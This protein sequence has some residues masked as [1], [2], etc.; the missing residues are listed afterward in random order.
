MFHILIANQGVN[1]YPGVH[2]LS[3][4]LGKLSNPLQTRLLAL[5]FPHSQMLSQADTYVVKWTVTRAFV[6]WVQ[7]A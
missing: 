2:I 5:Q 3:Q 6:I 1:E 4:H 7:T